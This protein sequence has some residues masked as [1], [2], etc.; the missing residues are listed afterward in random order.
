[1][2][3]IF[4]TTK[5]YRLQFAVLF[6]A[7]I[8]GTITGSFFSYAIGKIV[9]QIF[10]EKQMKGFL[11]SF[12]LYAGL[13]FSNQCFHG[14][15]NYVWAK[16]KVTYVVD[17][18]KQCFQHLMRLKA[19]IWTNIKSGDVMKRISDD[20]ES[21][22]EF[23]HRSLFY[24]LANFLQLS[25]SVGYLLYTNFC[26]GLIAIIMTPIMAY[27]VRY[28][29]IKLKER[30]Q[31]IQAGK[32]LVDAWILE[33]MTGIDQWKLLNAQNK[34]Q[35]D[36]KAK[37]KNIM[38]EEIEN[39]YLELKSQNVNE[40]LTLFGQLF[41]YCIVAFAVGKESMTIGQFVACAAYFSTCA[42]YFNALS[43]KI[44]EISSNIVKIK[45]VEEF[46][47]WEEEKDI[48]LAKDYIIE[49]GTICFDNVSFGYGKDLVLNQLNLQINE[50]EKVVFVGKSGEGKSTL[51]Q[52]LCRLYDPISG[53][54][55]IDGKRL[56]EYTIESVRRQVAVVLQ[57]NG[58]FHGSLR[59]NIIFSD[60][61]SQDARV[62]EILDGLK[63]KEI[64]E[65]FP[66]KLDTIMGS[67]ERELSGGQKQRIAIA[68]CIYRQPKIL[69]LDEAT[70]ALDET[71]EHLVNTYIYE[72]LPKTTILTVAHRFS[73]VLAAEKAIVLER[74]YITAVGEHAQLLQQNDLYRCLFEEY[75][76]SI[77]LKEEAGYEQY[78]TKA[79]L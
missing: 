11:L 44:T 79:A 29:S 66:N 46:M 8:S 18:R 41:I 31:K 20:T 1:M 77:Q 50:G 61:K 59:R 37:I 70:S 28:F 22:L 16:L 54:I 71:T 13:Y 42:T 30:H 5:G 74:G 10:Y 52:L 78:H 47:Q 73:T 4:N 17:I 12:F 27:S 34:V 69:L 63:L 6:F 57:E 51:L 40:A 14:V 2:R 68:R 62:W 75:Q 33:M 76:N 53:Q 19:S 35:K 48:V 72:Q 43:K 9:D 58:L 64:V 36:Y 23:I 55:Y 32:G 38:Q 56:S 65:E 7:V 49:N 26:L 21:F 3:Y 45:R 39:G 60:D 25:I 67:G 15:L 24:V